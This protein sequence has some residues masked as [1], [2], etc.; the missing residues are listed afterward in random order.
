MPVVLTYNSVTES[1][2]TYDDKLGE[3]YS[4]PSRYERL[5]QPG[6]RA[7]FYSGRRTSHEFPFAR[8]VG[9][10]VIGEVK[11]TGEKKGKSRILKCETLRVVTFPRPV[12]VKGGEGDYFESRANKAEYVGLF[13]QAG[14]REISVEDYKR[15]LRA[16]VEL[17]PVE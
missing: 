1:G 10:G 2:H 15:I 9:G 6:V 5:I 4:Y 17:D 16:A 13:F 14:V 11:D 12:P 7:L 3:Y 8:Y